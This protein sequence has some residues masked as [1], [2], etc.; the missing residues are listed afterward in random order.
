MKIIG[1]SLH[2][3]FRVT[4]TF[5]ERE[6]I[7]YNHHLNNDNFSAKCAVCSGIFSIENDKI[8]KLLKIEI[9][10]MN[11]EKKSYGDSDQYVVNDW[12]Y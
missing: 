2:F 12:R 5:S 10:K 9:I 11:N 4:K 7:I 6:D 1:T 8:S 3:L